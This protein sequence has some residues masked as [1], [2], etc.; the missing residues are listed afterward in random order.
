VD[1]THYVDERRTLD[2]SF[3]PSLRHELATD[4]ASTAGVEARD[5][6][7]G[8]L[9]RLHDV[10]GD[11]EVTLGELAEF[12]ASLTTLLAEVEAAI[13]RGTAS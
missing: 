1:T 9:E 3:L 4:P 12:R 8:A 11:F 2:T 7:R 13:G 5:V 6:L 10:V